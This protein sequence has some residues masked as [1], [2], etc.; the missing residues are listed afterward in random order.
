MEGSTVMTRKRPTMM[1]DSDE[2]E[3]GDLLSDL[4]R[5]VLKKTRRDVEDIVEGPE[6]YIKALTEAGFHPQSGDLPNI[7]DLQHVL[8]NT[9]QLQLFYYNTFYRCSIVRLSAVSL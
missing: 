5:P 6:D 2:D 9:F 4:P 3:E 8:Q 7:F 1:I